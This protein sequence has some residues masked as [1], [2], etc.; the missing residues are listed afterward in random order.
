MGGLHH[1]NVV[2]NSFDLDFGVSVA[3]RDLPGA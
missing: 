2:L 1:C 3:H